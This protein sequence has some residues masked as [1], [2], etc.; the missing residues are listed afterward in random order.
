MGGWRSRTAPLR[1]PGGPL[2]SQI[3]VKAQHKARVK[4]QFG[5]RPVSSA[6]VCRGGEL[7]LRGD[8]P[9]RASAKPHG[10]LCPG[11]KEGKLAHGVPDSHFKPRERTQGA[12]VRLTDHWHPEGSREE[13]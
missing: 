7:S 8:L 13:K 10:L 2:G 1:G 3:L 4:T 6:E 11:A 9:H 12:L 5:V